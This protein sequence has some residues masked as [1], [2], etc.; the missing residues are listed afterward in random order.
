LLQAGSLS[1]FGLTL[2][3]LLRARAE[4]AAFP[5]QNRP[6]VRGVILAFLTGGMSHLDSID[7]KPEAPK[8]IRGT[9]NTIKTALP[10]VRFTEH[11]PRLA[12]ALGEMTLVRSMQ[13]PTLVHEQAAHRMLCGVDQTPPGTGNTA[14]RRDRPHLGSL[15]ALARPDLTGV[16]AA[17]VLPNRLQAL[18][19]YPGQ[20]AGF[21]GARYDPWFVLGDPNAANFGP[22]NLALPAEVS[23]E[24]LG[25]RSELLSAIDNLERSAA[26]GSM[27]AHRQQA[28]GILTANTCRDAFDLSREHPAVRGRYGRNR[29]G[30]GL[31]LA[32]RLIEAGVPLVQVNMGNSEMWDTH[33]DNFR[34]LKDTLLP[35]L[36]RSLTALMEDL[37]LRGLRD[38]VLVVVTGEFGRAP[39]LGQAVPGGCGASPNGR[40]HWGNVFSMLA[41]GAG[42]GRGQVLGASD[43]LA[44]YPATTPYGPA[45][46]GANV[47]QALGVNLSAV[48][49]DDTGQSF[50]VNSGTP[51]PWG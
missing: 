4:A 2:P 36:D 51:I 40:D 46:V 21:L 44:A 13:T 33:G 24:R 11:L 7:P 9:F 10:G 35:P 29:M 5:Q 39:R 12:A 19:N 26:S 27:D 28:I 22:G 17:V 45:D 16:P 3:G 15:L 31:L 41:F 30:Q 8:E 47:L 49:R 18:G 50:P 1:F 43:R 48:L 20:N 38:E 37:T 23:V 6:R 25:E 34:L 42:V 32:R 14:S